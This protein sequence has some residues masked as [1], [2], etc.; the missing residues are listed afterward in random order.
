MFEGVGVDVV[1]G[2]HD[3]S[4]TRGFPI[5]GLKPLNDGD[6]S[7]V[8]F[9]L[10]SSTGTKYYDLHEAEMNYAAVTDGTREPPSPE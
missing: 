6:D 7:I 5:N 3:H 8:Y 1:F 9:C 10:G 2:G 4:Y